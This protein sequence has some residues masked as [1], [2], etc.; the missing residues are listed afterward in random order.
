MKALRVSQHTAAST[1]HV[2]TQR[3]LFLKSVALPTELKRLTV[4]TLRKVT[5]HEVIPWSE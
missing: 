1:L 4:V 2:S 3:L 5:T